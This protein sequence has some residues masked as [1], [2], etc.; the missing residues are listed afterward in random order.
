MRVLADEG[1]VLTTSG[2]GSHVNPK[3][4]WPK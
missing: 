4:M 3:E 1:Y 2:R